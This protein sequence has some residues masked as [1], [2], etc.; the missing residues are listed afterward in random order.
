[1]LLLLLKSEVE[2]IHR[3]SSIVNR[4]CLVIVDLTIIMYRN[5][6]QCNLTVLTF[7]QISRIRFKFH[8]SKFRTDLRAYVYL[9][10]SGFWLASCERG[11]NANEAYNE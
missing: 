2:V 11:M 3:P 10:P 1:M 6:Y 9:V 7:K 5:Q 4:W 8:L